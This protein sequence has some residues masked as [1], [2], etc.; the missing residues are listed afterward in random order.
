V[1]EPPFHWPVPIAHPSMGPEEVHI[2]SAGLHRSREE[3]QT[4]AAQLPAEEQERA[5]RYRAPL[6]HTQFVV[7][8]WTLRTLLGR[9]LD[10]APAEVPLTNGLRGKPALPA[11]L[12]LSFNVS[13]SHGLALFAFASKSEVGVDVEQ[14][15]S[16]ADDLGLAQRYF[17]PQEVAVL[18]AL[19]LQQRQETFFHIWT[20]KEAFLKAI[21]LGISYGVERVEVS[22]TPEEARLLRLDGLEAPA[23][24]WDMQGLRPAREYVGAVC[25][26][27]RL[28]TVR[29]WSFGIA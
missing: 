29:C 20:R 21:G 18:Q 1:N 15:R 19:A 5:K 23:S 7:A 13:H 28:G 10:L 17:C 4:L 6:A 9:Y 14:V 26:E 2:W 8:R 11:N 27:G 16:V 3:V 24:N 12:G 22:T 25:V